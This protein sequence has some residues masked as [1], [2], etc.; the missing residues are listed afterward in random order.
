MT[1]AKF[2]YI[3][4]GAGI[5]GLSTAFELLNR[6][7]DKKL[8][9][10]EKEGEC[11]QHQS[12]HNSGVIH[13][14]VYYA[15]GSLKAQ[16]CRAGVAA[17]THFCER[18]EIPYRTPGKLIV[19]TDDSE[20]A[21]LATLRANAE[22]NGLQCRSLSA[23]DLSHEEPHIIGAGA[24]HVRETGIVDYPAMCRQLEGLLRAAGASVQY[25]TEVI[26]IEEASDEV[27]V[28][29]SMGDFHGRTLVCC[30]GLQADRLAAMGGL[31]VDFAIVPFRGDYF[32]LP[33]ERNHLTSA[34]IYPVPNP[35][36]PFLGIHLTPEIHG[37]LSIGPSAMLALSR[38]SYEKWAF[39]RR[40]LL[41]M[42]GFA[43]LY[44][45]L[46]THISAGC[47]ELYRALSKRAYLRAARRYCPAL[48]LADLVTEGCGIR[49]QA[50]RSDGTMISDFL[51]K[52]SP[53][54]VHVCN[55]P[56]PAATSAFPIAATI[57][58]QVAQLNAA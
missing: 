16:L 2:D 56:S 29:T 49:A 31:E 36:L 22:K 45:L 21:G 13:A 8:L 3:V 1:S 24:F 53:R 57:A 15:P 30:S 23:A 58:E 20:L 43:G 25:G 28:E 10:V 46:A 26:G 32:R 12:G 42:A 48:T 14:G 19:A 54:S 33:A 34:L 51:I 5:I 17:T 39:D 38:E 11:A 50:V 7:P 44:R 4:I 41:A 9:L 55:A 6:S 40:D 35:K 18:Y 27:V 47:G 37:T 52:S